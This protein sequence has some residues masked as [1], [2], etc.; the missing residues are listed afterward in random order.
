[1]M[2]TSILKRVDASGMMDRDE[3]NLGMECNKK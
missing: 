2:D 1:M 3:Y